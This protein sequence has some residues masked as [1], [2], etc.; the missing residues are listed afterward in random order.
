MDVGKPLKGE[1]D[2]HLDLW[3]GYSR[4]LTERLN[5]R[6]QL[7]LRNVGEDTRLV[8]VTINPDRSIGFSRIQQ[9]MTWMLTNTFEF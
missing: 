6:V 1:T 4:R 9:G 3:V 5:W 7:N 8:P 2:D